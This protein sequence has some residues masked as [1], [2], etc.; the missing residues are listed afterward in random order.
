[1]GRGGG[2]K[3]TRFLFNSWRIS[4]PWAHNACKTQTKKRAFFIGRGKEKVC[5]MHWR[6]RYAGKSLYF[7]YLTVWIIFFFRSLVFKKEMKV[8]ILATLYSK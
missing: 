6:K 1:M 2:R 7:I 4:I 5:F 3:E 8:G